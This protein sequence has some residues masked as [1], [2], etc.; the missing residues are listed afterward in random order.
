MPTPKQMNGAP[1]PAGTPN[2]LVNCGGGDNYRIGDYYPSNESFVWTGKTSRLERG[3]AGWWGAQGGHANNDR[4]MMIG[5]VRDY[6]GPA[7]PGVNFLTRLTAL[8][9]VN[10]DVKTANL[11]ANPVPELVG[12]R[13][14][15]LI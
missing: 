2:H 12:L 15:K 11:V 7:G 8:R 10:W 4:M 3:Q 1:A 6:H 13:S 14:K 9:E 5:W